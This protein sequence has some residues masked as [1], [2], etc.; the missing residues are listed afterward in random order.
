MANGIP[1]TMNTKVIIRLERRDDK[2]EG[3][4]KDNRDNPTAKT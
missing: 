3:D 1:I 2:N 4:K